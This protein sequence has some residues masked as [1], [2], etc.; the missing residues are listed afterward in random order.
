MKLLCLLGSLVVK[1]LRSPLLPACPWFNLHHTVLF[2]EPPDNILVMDYVPDITV[3]NYIIWELCLGK[4][5]PGRI[6][7]FKLKRSPNRHVSMDD[8]QE[9]IDRGDFYYGTEP[10]IA[11]LIHK[12]GLETLISTQQPGYNLFRNNCWNFSQKC[13]QLHDPTGNI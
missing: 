5:I 11:P 3:T 2:D 4:S 13:T 6:R 12:Y 10:D 8:I 9:K 7:I 1:I